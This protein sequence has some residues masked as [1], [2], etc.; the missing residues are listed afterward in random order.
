MQAWICIDMPGVVQGASAWVNCR[1]PSPSIIVHAMS[2]HTAVGQHLERICLHMQV[3]KYMD[4]HQ[5]AHV[6]LH[7]QA[8]AFG[9]RVLQNMH[10]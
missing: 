1:C 4:I 8:K 9:L 10:R 6:C 3:E 2:T 7:E 5:G